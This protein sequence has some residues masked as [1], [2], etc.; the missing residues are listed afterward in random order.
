[1]NS[2]DKPEFNFVFNGKEYK[3]VSG[4]AFVSG[5]TAT[6]TPSG[7]SPQTVTVG[8]H[9]N[10]GSDTATNCTDPAAGGNGNSYIT[11]P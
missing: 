5:I 9:C 11:V 8:V 4:N 10:A 7:G 2:G 3:T 6:V 1:M